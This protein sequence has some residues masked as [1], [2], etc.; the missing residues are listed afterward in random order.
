LR[1]SHSHLHR[2]WTRLNNQI[3]IHGFR[4]TFRDWV[5]D[6]TTFDGESAE[7]CLA[8][9]KRGTEGAYHRATSLVKRRFI[10]AAWGAF[11]EGDSVQLRRVKESWAEF[12]KGGEVIEFQR[13]A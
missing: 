13:A 4:S 7:F 3:T 11:C 5:G 2:L 9:V 10:L 1:F 8:H 6:E 12:C